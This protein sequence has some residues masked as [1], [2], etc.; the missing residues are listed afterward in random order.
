V[1]VDI[2]T[3]ATWSGVTV[4]MVDLDLDVVLPHGGTAFIDDDDEF[5]VHRLRYDYP[6]GIVEAAERTSA[7]VLDAV[8]ARRPPFDPAT[9]RGWFALL[10]EG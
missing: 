4:T 9:A 2:T 3:P 7:L 6:P 1:Y 8:R 5:A 10:R